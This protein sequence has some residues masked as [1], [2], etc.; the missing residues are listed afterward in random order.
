MEGVKVKQ[1]T[2]SIGEIVRTDES[3][4]EED[5]AV[6]RDY[7]GSSV[8][9]EK[10]NEEL[11][12]RSRSSQIEKLQEVVC[13]ERGGSKEESPNVEAEDVKEIPRN[14]NKEPAQAS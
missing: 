2:N 8:E 7:Q 11:E 3:N 9:G 5:V 4:L 14:V 6:S 10:D 1:E 13:V 12:S